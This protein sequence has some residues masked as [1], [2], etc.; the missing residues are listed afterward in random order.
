[1]QETHSHPGQELRDVKRKWIRHDAGR[2]VLSR[3][4]I[5]ASRN[6]DGLSHEFRKRRLIPGFRFFL[7]ADEA[8]PAVELPLTGAAEWGRV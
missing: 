7:V 8:S 3:P 4:S 1:M 2:F 6:V 5:T